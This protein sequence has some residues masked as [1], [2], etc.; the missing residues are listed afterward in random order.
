MVDALPKLEYSPHV[1]PIVSAL[2]EPMPLRVLLIFAHPA[3]HRSRAN[4]V[5]VKAAQSVEG[6]TFHD[7]YAHYPSFDIDMEAEQQLLKTHDVLIFQHPFYWYSTPSL[8]KEWQD[9]V[10][11]YGWAYGPGGTA[12]KDKLFMSAITTSGS[13]DAYSHTGMHGRTMRELLAPL[14]QT[15]KLCQMQRL[16]PFVI[17]GASRMEPEALEQHATQYQRV[18]R[19]LV[20]GTVKL[21]QV[22][23]LERLNDDL[24]RLG[25]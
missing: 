6:V 17:H 25:G 19:A 8:L 1:V 24:N 15:F 22:A 5:L 11:E 13:R 18:L 12:L 2:G 10:L 4:K 9:L 3:F 21:E 16:P 23:E 14:D 20:A 7:L